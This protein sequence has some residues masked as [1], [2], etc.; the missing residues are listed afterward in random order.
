MRE[1]KSNLLKKKRAAA[2]IAR[3]R[4]REGALRGLTL[5]LDSH[6]GYALMG[7]LI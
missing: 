3:A 5:D 2:C 4:E 7:T 1:K 6:V